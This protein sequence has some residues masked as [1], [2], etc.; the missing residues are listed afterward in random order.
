MYSTYNKGK[1]VVAQRFIKTLKNKIYKHM[2]AVSK[3]CFFY[4]LND[5]VDQYNNTYDRTIKMKLIDV[6]PDSYAKC[7]VES[8]EKDP[9]FQVAG[10]IRISKNKNIFD[11]EYAPTWSGKI[12]WSAE[13]KAQ[14]HGLMLLV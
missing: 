13:L 14:F 11:K 12:L 2:N 3:K 8:N 5:I 10:H 6:K 1:S 7:S 9:K 4:F